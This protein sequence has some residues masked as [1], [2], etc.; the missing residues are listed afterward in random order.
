MAKVF[1]SHR[2]ADMSEATHLAESIRDAGHEVWL[3]AWEL[4]VGDNIIEKI[5]NGLKGADYLILCLSSHGVM[6]KWMSQEWMSTL[7]RQLNDQSVKLLPVR[8]TGGD[9]PAI[10]ADIK[11]ADLIANWSK[12][13]AALLKAI[14]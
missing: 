14:R 13:L 10:L 1:I 8:L 2:M 12:G 3:D 4:G 6:S 11:Y 9:L 7:A 5:N